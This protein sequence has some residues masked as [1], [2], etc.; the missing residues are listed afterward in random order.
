MITSGLRYMADLEDDP[1]IQQLLGMDIA[2]Y[3]IVIPTP[4]VHFSEPILDPRIGNIEDIARR[5]EAK[6]L[7]IRQKTRCK[8]ACPICSIAFNRPTVCGTALQRRS[9][10][11]FDTSKWN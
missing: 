4:P 8:A 3:A 1:A 2:F 6:L 11:N 5:Q 10:V 7:P 9:R